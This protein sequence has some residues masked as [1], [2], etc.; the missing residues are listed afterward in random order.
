M[1]PLKKKNELKEYIIQST[2]LLNSNKLGQSRLACHLGYACCDCCLLHLLMLHYPIDSKHAPPD[3][4]A[5]T[6][7]DLTELA[8]DL[9]YLS[10]CGLSAYLIS[11]ESQT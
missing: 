7:D 11:L 4:P 8:D 2:I 9:T 1:H 3:L 6:E 10:W 5:C